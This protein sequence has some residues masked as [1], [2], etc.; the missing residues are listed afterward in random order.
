[1]SDPERGVVTWTTLP[2]RSDTVDRT[3]QC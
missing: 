2:G 3:S 1:M